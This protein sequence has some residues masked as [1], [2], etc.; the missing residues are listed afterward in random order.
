MCCIYREFVLNDVNNWHW[1]SQC[2]PLKLIP[3]RVKPVPCYNL[4]DSTPSVLSG[5]EGVRKPCQCV[6][7]FNSIK[8][9]FKLQIKMQITSVIKASKSTGRDK[10]HP[11]LSMPALMKYKPPFNVKLNL[12]LKNKVSQNSWSLNRFCPTSVMFKT[13]T[14][15]SFKACTVS[16]SH[17]MTGDS[18]CV[19]FTAFVQFFW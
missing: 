2:L 14:S 8:R 11:S 4:S 7:Q 13:K 15:D 10:V 9:R 18:F 12:I 17:F 1:R 16:F 3:A 19:T 6:S 5:L